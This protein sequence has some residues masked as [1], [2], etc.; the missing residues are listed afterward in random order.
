LSEKVFPE[1]KDQSIGDH[2][3][4]NSQEELKDILSA[5]D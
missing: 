4:E 2:D 1:A 5:S 3:F